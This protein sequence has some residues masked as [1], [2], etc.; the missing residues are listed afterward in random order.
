MSATPTARELQ[1]LAACLR[2]GD[3]GAAYRL[4]IAYQTARN[5][6][7]ILF[8][9]LDVETREQAAIVLGWLVL[10]EDA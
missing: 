2:H 10:P 6:N 9:K 3:K 1:V 8:R 5:T 4:E 7:H